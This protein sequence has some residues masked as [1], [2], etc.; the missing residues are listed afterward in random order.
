MEELP[1]KPE[2]LITNIFFIETILTSTNT[3]H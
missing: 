2:V 3:W 1:T